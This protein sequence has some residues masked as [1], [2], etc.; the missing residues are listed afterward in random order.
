[1]VNY[2]YYLEIDTDIYRILSINKYR[3]LISIFVI[4]G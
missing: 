4:Y 1:M 3:Y 2:I